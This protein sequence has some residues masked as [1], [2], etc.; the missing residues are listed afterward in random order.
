MEIKVNVGD[1]ASKKTYTFT[2]SAE[3]ASSVHDKRIGDTFR[4][5][6]IGKAGY[7]L[8][9]T[10]GSDN[11]GFP[12]RK[13]VPGH[14]RQKILI[15]KSTGNQKTEKGIRI[16]KTVAGGK[17]GEFTAQINCKV[18][19]AG[20]DS[21]ETKEEAPAEDAPTEEK[22]EKPAE[23]KKEDAPKEEK[24]EEKPAE[25][26]KKE[27]TPKDDKKETPEEKKE[28]P[29]EDKQEEKKDDKP[30]E[31]KP[32]EKPKEEAPEEKKEEAPKEKP[33]EPKKEEKRS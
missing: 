28:A 18:V 17:V 10:G 29:K 22:K 5:E 20:K 8:E 16:R 21:L 32:A 23:E 14:R 19:K 9:I 24:K 12:M 6:L 11:A 15:T 4:G 30:V 33:A 13:D 26:E 27:D 1:P 25:E 3:D 31:E 7:E 2:I